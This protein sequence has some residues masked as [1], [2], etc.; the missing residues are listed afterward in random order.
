MHGRGR[1]DFCIDNAITVSAQ[2]AAE[3]DPSRRRVQSCVEPVHAIVGEHSAASRRSHAD[4]VQR[5]YGDEPWIDRAAQ[6]ERE[7][8][9][10]RQGRRVVAPN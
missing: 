7:L 8:V 6:L 2:H 5:C 4:Y 1:S 9:G 10:S 3:K